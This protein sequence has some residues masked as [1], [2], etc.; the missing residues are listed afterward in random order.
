[1]TEPTLPYDLL[2]HG[3]TIID[4]ETNARRKASVAVLNGAI[5]AIGPDL[6]LRHAQRI[7]DVNG[8]FVTPG[9]IDFHAHG[10]WGATYDGLKVDPVAGRSGVTTWVDAGSSGAATFPAFREYVIAPSRTRILPFLNLCAT[11]IIYRGVMEFEDLRFADVRFAIETIEAHRDLIV[12]IKI[13][14]DRGTVGNNNDHPL[15]LAREVADHVGLP[16]MVHIG[17][18][19]PALHQILAG[20][21]AG[22]II[23][24]AFRG[25]ERGI[26]GI[27]INGKIRPEVWEARARG[28]HFDI[29]HG[30]GSF[31]IP[32]AR[33][34]LA[35]GFLPDT[36]STDLHQLSIQPG[37]AVDLPTVLSKF[38]ALGMSL[39]EVIQRATVAPARALGRTDQIGS[40]RIGAPADLAVF[41]LVDGD[42]I[43]HDVLGNSI[44][45]TQQ[46]RNT[47]TLRGGGEMERDLDYGPLPL[48]TASRSL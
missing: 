17:T 39:E 47:L 43:F 28:V 18:P 27:V 11:G 24:H 5:A 12:G 20:L 25:D 22:D 44:T 31:G 23:T 9:L 46:L 8:K 48:F 45:G 14:L 19:P 16:I 41:D 37:L 4:P 38:M 3:G 35:E 29:G 13:R 40:F 33:I 34:A 36:I 26:G 15:W 6:Q 10:Y 1:M 2:L 42:F 21:R 7:V 32:A 30:A